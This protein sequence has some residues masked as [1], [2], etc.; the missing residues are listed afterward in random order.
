MKLKGS[1]E[2]PRNFDQQ[3]AR[4]SVDRR[5]EPPVVARGCLEAR[6]NEGLEVWYQWKR[7]PS[8]DWLVAVLRVQGSRWQ[9]SAAKG[10]S[11]LVLRQPWDLVGD[12]GYTVHTVDRP[13]FAT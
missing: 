9:V 11:D 12:P 6:P 10:R 2:E 7:Q 3:K 8:L 1:G 5:C 13:N 4:A